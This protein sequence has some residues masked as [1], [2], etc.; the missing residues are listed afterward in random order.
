MIPNRLLELSEQG[1][2]DCY[3]IAV[4]FAIFKHKNKETGKC[5]PSRRTLQRILK[6]SPE[7][8]EKSIKNLV[9]CNALRYTTTKGVSSHYTSVSFN[10]TGCNA[11]RNKT[12]LNNNTNKQEKN[13]SNYKGRELMQTAL[14]KQNSGAYN[15]LYR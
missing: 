7:R 10:D 3:D 6:T 9:K 13:F 8:I 12:I 1:E 15:K 2:I 5:Y 4:Y 14:K 11:T